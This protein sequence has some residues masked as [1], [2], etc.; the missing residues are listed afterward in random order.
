[1]KTFDEIVIDLDISGSELSDWIE[2]NW[3]MPSQENG[4]I[5]FN[6]ED[7]ARARLLKEML[8]DIGANEAS[9][10]VILRSLDQVYNLRKLLGQLASAIQELPAETRKELESIIRNKG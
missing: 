2:R 3:V 1:M 7:E 4:T 9:I 8:H 6:D 5:L 10:P